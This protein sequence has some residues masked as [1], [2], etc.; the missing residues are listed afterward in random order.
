MT[1]DDSRVGRDG[2]FLCEMHATESREAWVWETTT[3]VGKVLLFA[4]ARGCL[5]ERLGGLSQM[6]SVLDIC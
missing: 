3:F 1:K 6:P 2:L 4:F 5:P